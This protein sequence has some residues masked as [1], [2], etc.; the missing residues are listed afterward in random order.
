TKGY[1]DGLYHPEIVCSRDQMA[2]FIARALAGG[3][4]AVPTPTVPQTFLDIPDGIPTFP[5][6]EET[7][8]WAYK[9]IEYCADRGIVEGFDERGALYYRPLFTVT[10][11]VMAVF[12]ARANGW[13]VIGEDMDT[14]GD[15]FLDLPAGYWSGTAIEA[16]ID[17]GVVKGYDDGLY[18]P[19]LAV[20]RD[21]MAVFIYRAFP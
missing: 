6:T 3:D 19:W 5:A 17:N 15:L 18:R 4:D 1:L 12:M 21:Q 20:T 7:Q 11:D 16:C 13:V 9:Y 14:A 10:R 2:V 8:H